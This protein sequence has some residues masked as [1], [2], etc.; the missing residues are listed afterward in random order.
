MS[1]C[2]LKE[3]EKLVDVTRRSFQKDRTLY[4]TIFSYIGKKLVTF[5]RFGMGIFC[6]F[7]IAKIQMLFI[8][9]A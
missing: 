5:K 4:T 1:Y 2:Q 3:Y 9:M 6:H 8:A 7:L